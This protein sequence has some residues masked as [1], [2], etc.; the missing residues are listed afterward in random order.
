MSNPNT[1]IEYEKRE[2]DKKARQLVIPNNLHFE[3]DKLT[4][5]RTDYPNLE[6]IWANHCGLK[7]VDLDLPYL[8]TLSL[9]GNQLKKISL[10][11]ILNLKNLTIPYNQLV[12]LDVW[13]LDNLETLHCYNNRLKEL[14]ASHLEK[15]EDVNCANNYKVIIDDEV[16]IAYSDSMTSLNLEG[17]TNLKY[18]D[19]DLN[20]LEDLSF[21]S[22]L[23]KLEEISLKQNK[24]I[25]YREV[26]EIKDGED[27][28]YFLDPKPTETI[29]F[30]SPFLTRV[31]ISN[32]NIKNW[33][34]LTETKEPVIENDKIDEGYANSS[35]NPQTEWEQRAYER[36]QAQEKEAFEKGEHVWKGQEQLDLSNRD[37]IKSITIDGNDNYPKS[38]VSINLGGNYLSEVIVRNMPN[39]V[40]LIISHNKIGNLVIENCPKLDLLYD[41][42][43]GDESRVAPEDA[44]EYQEEIDNPLR[45]EEKES[46]DEVIKPQNTA[47][48]GNYQQ[49]IVI[50]G[51]LTLLLILCLVVVRMISFLAKKAAT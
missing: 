8:E 24:G 48:V 10:W 12:Q 41:Y 33:I 42:K 32:S 9:T 3:N 28:L 16:E 13:F 49:L 46:K 29:F 15:L 19:A 11:G 44:K 18:L 22:K 38:L 17:S 14:N 20:H 21:T 50:T 26:S 37:Y 36:Q 27:E 45:E 34:N 7:E 31:D 23:P 51:F 1:W 25:Q 4:I 2:V 47:I 6:V 35:E 39:L 43:S 30:N 40:R 5:K